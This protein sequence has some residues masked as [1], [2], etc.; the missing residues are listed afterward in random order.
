MAAVFQFKQAILTLEELIASHEEVYQKV[1]DNFATNV[2]GDMN[3]VIHYDL[4][5]DYKH[6]LICQIYSHSF[7]AAE[8]T[9]RH[10]KKIC[11]LILAPNDYEEIMQLN[12]FKEL[13]TLE[14][15]RNKSKA[16]QLTSK[17]PPYHEIVK[18]LGIVEK[19][20]GIYDKMPVKYGGKLKELEQLHLKKSVLE[21]IAHCHFK[22][23]KFA[24]AIVYYVQV[25]DLLTE[26]DQVQ[27]K[28]I[29]FMMIECEMEMGQVRNAIAM[30][31]EL[32][33]YCM[34]MTTSDDADYIECQAKKIEILEQ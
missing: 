31:E 15:F 24:D 16:E 10:L 32:V 4:Y 28:R 9:M 26:F 34:R 13:I 11:S 1:N 30:L 19:H 5:V 2:F 27:Y 8:E 18:R 22:L 29:H 21:N 23:N 12:Y 17:K 7:E 33:E 20:I 6:L 25:L 14:Q 3:L